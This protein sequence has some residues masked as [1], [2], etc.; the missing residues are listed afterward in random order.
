MTTIGPQASRSQPQLTIGIQH[1]YHVCLKS[2]RGFTNQA[3][4]SRSCRG[5]SCVKSVLNFISGEEM[6]SLWRQREMTAVA[7]PQLDICRSHNQKIY[8]ANGIKALVHYCHLRN[9]SCFEL[10]LLPAARSHMGTAREVCGRISKNKLLKSI[11]K[12]W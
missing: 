4:R 11:R 6:T 2:C 12:V 1:R 9:S 3:V 5:L 8:R 7:Q 10:G